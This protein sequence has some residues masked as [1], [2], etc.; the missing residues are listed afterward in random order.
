MGA[1][2]VQVETLIRQTLSLVVMCRFTMTFPF[3]PKRENTEAE[4]EAQQVRLVRSEL[5]L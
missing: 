1:G 3:P 4:L 2:E 5:Y